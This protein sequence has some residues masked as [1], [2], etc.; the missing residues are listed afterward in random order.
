MHACSSPATGHSIH[1][2]MPR[3]R[4]LLFD[5]S[6]HAKM[7][8]QE[9]KQINETFLVFDSLRKTHKR[10][11]IFL[12]LFTFLIALTIIVDLFSVLVSDSRRGVLIF[13]VK[14]LVSLSAHC[15]VVKGFSSRSRMGK[16][17]AKLNIGL[18]H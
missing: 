17:N 5:V 1:S 16:R 10:K 2:Q 8:K 9:S 3:D 11:E 15:L 12:R 7:E 13:K 4:V 6:F 14:E 18:I